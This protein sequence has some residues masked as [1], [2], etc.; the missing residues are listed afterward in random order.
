MLFGWGCELFGY[1]LSSFF[2]FL[3]YTTFVCTKHVK[4]K[5]M[6]KKRFSSKEAMCDV[7]ISVIASV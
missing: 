5:Y 1:L 4:F 7:L 3:A 2:A 6:F